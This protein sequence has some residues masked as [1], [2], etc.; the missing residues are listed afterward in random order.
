M[1]RNIKGIDKA[2]NGQEALNK[3]TSKK[4][5][6]GRSHQ[7][8]KIIILDNNMPILTGVETAKRIRA[9]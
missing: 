2:F 7:A 4:R 9:L 3:L 6:C 8:F 1:M 5:E